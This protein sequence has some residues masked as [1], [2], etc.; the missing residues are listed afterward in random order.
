M[1]Q[2]T[3]KDYI[4]IFGGL[5]MCVIVFFVKGKK[6]GERKKM[7]AMFGGTAAVLGLIALASFF[8]S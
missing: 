5:L 7:L 3:V 6:E 1:D 8:I 2:F 4:M